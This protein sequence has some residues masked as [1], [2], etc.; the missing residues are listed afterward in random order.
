MQ[1]QGYDVAA[2]PVDNELLTAAYKTVE[3]FAGL[4]NRR[5][6]LRHGVSAKTDGH[7]VLVPFTDPDFYLLIE[8]QLAHILF[9]SDAKARNRFVRAVMAQ[10]QLGAQHVRVA[11]GKMDRAEEM[12]ARIIDILESHRIG[13][14]WGL[15]YPG[16]YERSCARQQKE[17]ASLLPRAHDSFF[18][19][20]LCLEAELDVPKGD[21]DRFKPVFVEAFQRVER[22]GFAATLA[23]SRWLIVRLV[24]ELLRE[25]E[26]GPGQTVE[27]ASIAGTVRYQ[28]TPSL[29]DARKRIL[30]FQSLVGQFGELD[31]SIAAQ[32]NDYSI[33]PKTGDEAYTDTQLA[34]QQALGLDMADA[35]ALDATLQDSADRMQAII[36]TA[37]KRLART[38]DRDDWLRRDLQAEISFVDVGPKD[39]R[40]L[41]TLQLLHD[42]DWSIVQRLRSTFFRVQGRRA[43]RL[44]ETGT[45]VDIPAFIER[46]ITGQPLPCFRNLVS[47]R[48]FRALILVD[49]SHSMLEAGRI[50]Q[51]ERGAK[52]ITEAL[53]FPFVTLDLWGFQSL[54]DGEVTITR[55]DP[56]LESFHTDKSPVDGLTPLH[57]A[58]RLAVRDMVEG[59]SAK[60]L[61]VLTDG[62]PLYASATGKLFSEKKLQHFVREEVQAARRV[63]INVTTFLIGSTVGR[64]VH[65]EV[66]PKELAYM[67]GPPR[68]WKC[69]DEARFGEDLVA[70]VAKSF[71]AYLSSN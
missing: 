4:V 48:G 14:L 65:F 43:S 11:L 60:Q 8:R 53:D 63:G 17:R 23:I 37:Q 55:F 33:A 3:T 19:L 68:Y 51:A 70:A 29:G 62:A 9:R 12:L 31:A 61:F 28:E 21:L 7:K 15:I 5:L 64:K 41:P 1:R 69:V 71:C 40:G 6:E 30:A 16:S 27:P 44:E 54:Q 32:Y 2:P 46:Q 42:T 45:E 52:I 39:L 38:Y 20:M 18:D 56:E 10:M 22:R 58:L 66:G 25:D 59:H 35:A 50:R 34:T 49:R 13:S 67:F 57:I 24:D 36:D 47:G 26:E